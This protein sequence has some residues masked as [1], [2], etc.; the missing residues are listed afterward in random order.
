MNKQTQIQVNNKEKKHNSSFDNIIRIIVYGGITLAFIGIWT[1]KP[2]FH[3]IS[4]FNAEN[5]YK[6]QQYICAFNNYRNAFNLSNR[7]DDYVNNYFQT[8]KKM[9]K[10]TIVQEELV[11]ILDTYPDNPVSEEIKDIFKQL[12]E[13]IKQEYP[14]TYIENVVQGTSVIHWNNIAKKIHVY[15]DAS[16]SETFPGYYVTEVQNAFMAYVRALENTIKF[17]FVTDPKEADILVYY[18]ENI[19]DTECNKKNCPK[20]LG[21]TEND[22]VGYTLNKSIIQL[23]TKDIDNSLFTQNQ[24]YNISKHE[25]GHALGISGHSYYSEDVMYPV[26]NDISFNAKT[27]SLQVERKEFSSRDLQ[28]IK[29]LY[30]IIPDI[31][32][33]KYITKNFP[34]MYYPIA[35]LGPKD[36]IA[37]KKLE[38]S[39]DYLNIVEKNFISQINLAES[40][41]ANKQ[42]EK[43]K[44]TFFIALK[45]AE[46]DKERFL[47]YNNLAVIAYDNS[48]YDES[49]AFAEMAN[50]YSDI[51]EADE[52]KAYCY[53][54]L[55]KYSKAEKLLLGLI[56]NSSVNP[57]YSSALVGIY[58]KQCKFFQA[59]NEL[60]RIKKTNADALQTPAFE[61]YKFFM[62]F[63]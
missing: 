30:K 3:K 57:V 14:I 48:N 52:I 11:K 29:L 53:I 20:I 31:T 25:I 4:I 58:I 2:I 16:V 37:A 34:D 17:H 8:L 50:T 43:A 13:K 32:N 39:K 19:N 15:I 1:Y 7:N 46:S 18:K 44:D 47:V 21:L 45:Y 9:K 6:N 61:Q 22:S 51:N 56:E 62:L 27:Y 33:Q 42:Y 59:I 24:I 54:E 40:Y 38:E 55:K 41:F 35:V 23:R 12:Q 63:V 36:E 26:S 49:L 10:V 28:T 5:C 60:K